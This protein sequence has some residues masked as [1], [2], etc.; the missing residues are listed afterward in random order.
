MTSLPITPGIEKNLQTLTAADNSHNLIGKNISC[1]YSGRPVLNNVDISVRSGEVLCLL[2]PNGVGKTTLFRTLLGLLPI[3]SGEVLIDGADRRSLSRQELA[4]KVA[5]VPQSHSPSFSFSVTDVVLTG[6][7]AHLGLFSAPTKSEYE[8][9]EKVMADVGIWHLKDRIYSQL[10]GGE[11]QMALIARALMQDADLLIMDEPAASLDMGKQL[12]LL[13]RI[14]DMTRQGKGIIMST[15]NPD[16]CFLCGTTA[17]LITPDH[18]YI[19]GRV[20]DVVTEEN[21]FKAFGVHCRI[22]TAADGDGLILRGCI[23]VF[24]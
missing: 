24:T 2:G 12:A 11:R 6:C 20:D 5:Y 3:I 10:S 7:A 19:F 4:C 21:L 16:H 1:G 23:P 14:R 18:Q 9:A 15:H 17:L 8:R 13:S 22:L